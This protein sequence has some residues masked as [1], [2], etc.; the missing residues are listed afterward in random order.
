LVITPDLAGVGDAVAVASKDPGV[1]IAPRSTVAPDSA[2][3]GDAA[4][5]ASEDPGVGIASLSRKV[6]LSQYPQASKARTT[7]INRTNFFI[8]LLF[9]FLFYMFM[10]SGK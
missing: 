6:E 9:P 10:H 2:G 8:A 7:A 1:G 5:F 3:V 4:T